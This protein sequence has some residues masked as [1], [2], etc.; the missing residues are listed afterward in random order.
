MS[1]IGSPLKKHHSTWSVNAVKW[2]ELRKNIFAALL[3]S[4]GAEFGSCVAPG[5][6]TKHITSVISKFHGA[7]REIP[8]AMLQAFLRKIS[9]TKNSNEWISFI[10]KQ[11]CE[12]AIPKGLLNYKKESGTMVLADENVMPRKNKWSLS[13][14][15]RVLSARGKRGKLFCVEFVKRYETVHSSDHIARSHLDSFASQPIFTRCFK[16][17]GCL[18]DLM[19]NDNFLY[20]LRDIILTEIPRVK[21]QRFCQE[22]AIKGMWGAKRKQ[23]IACCG[24][25]VPAGCQICRGCFQKGFSKF[26]D[27]I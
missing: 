14:N 12:E 3:Y 2:H 13:C 20:Y 19:Y 18:S 8:I 1:S 4:T 7:Y 11:G 9:N 22:P 21:Q 25:V 6:M 16:R 24:A 5:G 15:F 26:I 23:Y 17:E 10:S 27:S